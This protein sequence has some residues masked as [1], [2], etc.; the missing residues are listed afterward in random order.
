MQEVTAYPSLAPISDLQPYPYQT[1]F[2]YLVCSGKHQDRSLRKARKG[3]ELCQMAEVALPGVTGLW[4]LA[5][6][7]DRDK[8]VYV[9]L[10]WAAE[11]RTMEYVADTLQPVWFSGWAYDQ[12]TIYAALC[13]GSQW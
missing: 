1:P 2:D 8:Y 9:V 4:T 11:T 12:P 13:T 5:D 3:I 7:Y 10:S 6:Q